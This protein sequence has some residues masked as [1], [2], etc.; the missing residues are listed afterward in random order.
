[1]KNTARI[2]LVNV[3]LLALLLHVAGLSISYYHYVQA[4]ERYLGHGKGRVAIPFQK[5][6]LRWNPSIRPIPQQFTTCDDEV[7][8]YWN[9]PGRYRMRIFERDYAIDTD[10]DGIRVGNRKRTEAGRPVLVLGDSHSWGLGVDDGETYTA[11]LNRMSA[12]DFTS[13]SCASFGTARAF[14]KARQLI[15]QDNIERPRALV[16]QYCF[17]DR[18]ENEGFVES[19]FQYRAGIFRRP[20]RF[21]ISWQEAYAYLHPVLRP[22]DWPG[23]LTRYLLEPVTAEIPLS[24]QSAQPSRSD[25]FT[26]VCAH[27]L[28]QP[29]FSDVEKVILILASPPKHRSRSA[30]EADERLL[31]RGAA[32]L[33][34]VCGLDA[35]FISQGDHGRVEGEYFEMEDHLNPLGHAR[36]ADRIRR[37]LERS[38]PVRRAAS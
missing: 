5:I 2:V 31:G 23:E 22:W 15:R 6:F 33:R 25:A 21:R 1:M 3:I 34:E 32:Y 7:T 38:R 9:S 36:F 28:G 12:D 19:G 24:T 26:Q 11:I 27:F 8:H 16:I 30:Y 29:E 14:L 4:R 10:A 20:R 37:S 17:N 18:P 13:V 35:E